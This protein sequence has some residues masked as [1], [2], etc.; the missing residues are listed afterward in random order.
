MA[1]VSRAGPRAYFSS[2]ALLPAIGVPVLAFLLPAGAIFGP[3]LGM[4]MVVALSLAALGVNFILC[5][6]LARYVMRTL[7]Q[8]ILAKFGYR[9]PQIAKSDMANIAIIVRVT[10]G[11]PF[12]VQNYLLGIA[13]VPFVQYT[14]VS[15]LFSWSYAVAFVLSGDALMHGKGK[16]AIMAGSLLIAAFAATHYARKHYVKRK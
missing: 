4:G 7:L 8:N 11:I 2:M 1:V 12:F 10:P 3:Q 16:V 5:Y 9:L 6:I 15:C 14:M 13:Q